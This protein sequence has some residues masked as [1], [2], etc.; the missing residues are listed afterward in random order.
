MSR[1]KKRLPEGLFDA[2]IEALSHD[3]RGVARLDGKTTFIDNALAGEQVRFRYTWT[4]RKF[5]E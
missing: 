4:R 3:G 5:D 2:T 1:R